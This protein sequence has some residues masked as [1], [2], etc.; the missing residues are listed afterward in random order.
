MKIDTKAEKFGKNGVKIIFTGDKQDFK[1]IKGDVIGKSEYINIVY[2]DDKN[3][4]IDDLKKQIDEAK[5]KLMPLQSKLDMHNF[6]EEK[7]GKVCQVIIDNNAKV[8]AAKYKD[9]DKLITTYKSREVL[10]MQIDQLKD[11]LEKMQHQLK[12]VENVN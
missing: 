9:L 4:A 1:N 11:N 10:K 6:N 5:E 3:N 7:F 2:F 8:T 12:V